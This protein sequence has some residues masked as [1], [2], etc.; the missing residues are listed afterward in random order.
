MGAFGDM[1]PAKA[2]GLLVIASVV[3]LGLLRK[4]FGSVNVSLGS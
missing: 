4:Y 1:D 2:A 3:A